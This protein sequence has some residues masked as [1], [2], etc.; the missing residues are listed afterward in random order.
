MAL[1]ILEVVR[2]LLDL[3]CARADVRGHKVDWWAS[4]PERAAIGAIEDGVLGEELIA[5]A[6]HC[7]DALDGLA[8]DNDILATCGQPTSPRMTQSLTWIG[9]V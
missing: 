4:E 6:G 8:A 5:P 1:A 9:P 7:G 3:K 2:V